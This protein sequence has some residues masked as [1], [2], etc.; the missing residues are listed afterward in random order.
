MIPRIL[1]YHKM[2]TFESGFNDENL[3]H[4]SEQKN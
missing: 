1:R 3:H 2:R 4:Q